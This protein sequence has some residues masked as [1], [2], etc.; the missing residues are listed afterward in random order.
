MVG[1]S[2]SSI[3][4]YS[5]LAIKAIMRYVYLLSYTLCPLKWAYFAPNETILIAMAELSSLRTTSKVGHG[6]ALALGPR[7]GRKRN[8]QHVP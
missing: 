8:E 2:S 3:A 4:T 7:F 5:A 1:S 6:D